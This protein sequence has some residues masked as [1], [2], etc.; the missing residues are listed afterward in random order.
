[1]VLGLGNT[2]VDVAGLTLLQRTAP[3]DVIGRVFGVLEM[4][5]VGTIGLGAALAPTLIDVV[6]TRWSLVAVGAILPALA[7]LTWRSLVRID[8]ESH[9]P[10][11]LGLLER[12]DIFAP[13][14]APALERLASQLEPVTVPAGTEVIRQGDHGDRFYIVEA[15]RLIVSVDGAPAREI[16]P[17]DFFGEIALLRDLPRTASVTAESDAQLQALGRAAFLDAVTG[18][19]PSARAADAVVGARLAVRA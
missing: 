19:P 3:P 9:A 1:M 16:G 10:G 2:L 13:L 4:I 12:I 17:G 5:L 11:Q 14:P 6:G 7:A 15:G 8:V 18:S